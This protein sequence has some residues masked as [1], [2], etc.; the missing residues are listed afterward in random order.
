MNNVLQ[1]LI[2]SIVTGLDRYPFLSHDGKE[3]VNQDNV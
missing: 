2:P 3:K 1:I